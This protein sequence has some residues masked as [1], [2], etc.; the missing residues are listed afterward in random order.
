MWRRLSG[1]PHRRPAPTMLT[2][3]D[4]AI[5]SW[6]RGANA[7]APPLWGATALAAALG[8]V[9]CATDPPQPVS[10]SEQTRTY[11]AVAVDR[12]EALSDSSAAS[13]SAIA[14]FVS[15]PAFSDAGRVLV[16]A[17]ATL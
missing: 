3:S 6:P 5:W 14:R 17:G 4:M 12:S 15:I 1:L 2:A 7:V 10:D 9:A 8:T 11:L 13:A 16:A